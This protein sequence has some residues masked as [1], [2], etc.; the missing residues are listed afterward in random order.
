MKRYSPAWWTFLALRI[1]L[2]G[3]FIYAAYT[4]LRTNFLLFAM[5]IN[6]YRLLPE[7]A[8][9]ALARVLPWAE[10]LLGIALVAGV[11]LRLSSAACTALL[12]VF[13]SVM[14]R[15]Y[16]LTKQTG[17]QQVYC[18]CFGLGEPISAHTLARD[19]GL[20]FVAVL[21]TVMAF[22]WTHSKRAAS[23]EAAAA[24]EKGPA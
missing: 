20:V 16:Y 13:F 22:W 5:A 23:A 8:A 11:F 6:A 7:N 18:G 9:V 14:L 21:V 19:G 3:I 17:E 10:L 1:F 4:K 2:G 15:S 24:L 12:G